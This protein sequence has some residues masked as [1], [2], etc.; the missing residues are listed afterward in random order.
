MQ[1]YGA[2]A[3][4]VDDNATN[5]RILEEILRNWGMR[6]ASAAGAGEALALLGEAARLNEPFQIV[7]SDVNMPDVDGFALVER[8]RKDDALRNSVFIMLTSA[9]R[10]GDVGPLQGARQSALTSSSR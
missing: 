9:T 2:K 8:C 4:I 10:S 3:L 1:V 5:R 6:T 7:L